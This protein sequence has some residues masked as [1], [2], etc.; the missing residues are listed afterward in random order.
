MIALLC[1]VSFFVVGAISGVA[2]QR[3]NLDRSEAYNAPNATSTDMALSIIAR[4]QGIMTNN[5]TPGSAL[6]AGIVQK[7]FAAYNAYYG[8]HAQIQ[9]YIDH[10]TISAARYM[11]STIDDVKDWPLDRLSNGNAMLSGN[12]PAY[13][14]ALDALRDSV[15]LNQRNSENGL[16]Y[17]ESYPE[18]SYLDGMYSLGPFAALDSRLGAQVRVNDAVTP[19]TTTRIDTRDTAAIEDMHLQFR[20]LWDHCY[21]STTGLL[22]HGYDASRKASWASRTNGASAVVWGRSLGW[23]MMAL[24]DTLELLYGAATPAVP[25]SEPLLSMYQRLAVAVMGYADK[26]SGGW[27]QV[28]DM[29]GREGNYVESSAT[30]MFSYALLKGARLRYLET[31]DITAAREAGRAAHLLLARD[32]VT[33]EPDGTLGFNGTVAVCSLNSSATY[34]Y[35]VQQP[36]APNSVLG[37]AAFVLASLEVE[38]LDDNPITPQ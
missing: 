34:D 8:R 13:G 10:S 33:A 22:V 32:F 7:A 18:W 9:E 23:F 5:T 24:V 37:T 25:G 20:L 26:N 17:W 38:R 27:Y 28:V 4:Q 3:H 35:Y 14:A 29:A 11:A 15:R 2:S 30:A 6:Q 12:D 21:N 36:M 19:P 16:W 1:L 31:S